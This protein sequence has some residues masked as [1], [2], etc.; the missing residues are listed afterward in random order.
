MTR[1]ETGERR[2]P[3]QFRFNE[4]SIESKGQHRQ[5]CAP[6]RGCFRDDLQ[7]RTT[8]SQGPGYDLRADSE[9]VG[10][11]IQ[12]SVSWLGDACHTQGRPKYSLAP[13]DK[14]TRGHLD[15]EGAGSQSRSPE[16]D[17]RGGGHLV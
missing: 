6:V 17:A 15:R 13:G 12:P 8:D 3:G 1:H 16:V 2:A 5:D 11:A 14:L 9:T 4:I 10:R 7:D